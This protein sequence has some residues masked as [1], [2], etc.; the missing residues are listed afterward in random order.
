MTVRKTINDY[1]IAAREAASQA[2]TYA[3]YPGAGFYSRQA[4]NAYRC[5]MQARSVAQAKR[6]AEK[7]AENATRARLMAAHS[8]ARGST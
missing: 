8:Q 1:R 5:A 2:R 6:Y 4:D 7:A 3:A